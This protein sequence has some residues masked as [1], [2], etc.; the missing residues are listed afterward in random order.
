M[1]VKTTG[2]EF[3]AFYN[4]EGFWPKG[5]WHDDT[6]ILVNGK[7]VD[8]YTRENIPDDAQL[9]LDG[10][11]VFLD[12]RGTKDTGFEAH[13]KKWR[14]GQNTAYLAVECPKDKLEAVKAAIRAAG[15][16]VA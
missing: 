15:G 16:K 12:E 3:W 9:V 8:D 10:G 5:A 2:A 4:D 6:L 11:V 1:T 7:E 13:F 14:K